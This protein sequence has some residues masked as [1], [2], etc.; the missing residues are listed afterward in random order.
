[1]HAETGV[2]IKPLACRLYP[3]VPTPGAESVRLDLRADCPSV[4]ANRGRPLHV[5]QQAIGQFAE[6]TVTRPMRIL[7]AW[8]G[9][10]PLT[11][12]E[13]EAVV[14]AFEGLLS[15]TPLSLR[16]RLRAGTILLDLLY[17]ARISKVR[18]ERFVEMMDLL[19]QAVVQEAQSD[20][21]QRPGLSLRPGRLFRQW[22]FLHAIADDPA[23]LE[24]GRLQRWRRSWTRYR[25][26][27][28]FV[29]ASGPIPPLRPDWPPTEFEAVDRVDRGDDADL[30]PLIRSMRVKL[31]AH[32][33]C[34]PGYYGYDLLG[35]LTALWLLPAVVGWFARLAAV[36]AGR[37]VLSADDLMAGLRRAHHTFGVSP[38]F[39]RISERLRLKALAR[40]GIAGRLLDRYGP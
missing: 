20:E 1:M 32:A 10:R 17:A 4:A 23:D 33:F 16:G 39:A 6:E 3:F 7:P 14:S 28:R 40:P 9:E 26:S 24:A 13:F 30:E 8:G 29:E 38:V 37:S 2:H 22:L 15:R 25:Q 34:G 11:V 18:D 12:Q 5:H 21:Q 35:G 36:A 19:A 27:R 31:E